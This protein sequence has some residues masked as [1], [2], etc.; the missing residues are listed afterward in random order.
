MP[1]HILIVNPD[2]ALAGSLREPLASGGFEVVVA[3]DFEEAASALKAQPFHAIVTAHHLGSHNGLHLVLRARLDRPT[4]V[5][6][7]TSAI[8]D[9]QLDLEAAAFGAV[10][11]VQPWLDAAPLLDV[12]RS[13]GAQPTV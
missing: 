1:P 12:L 7:I 3:S 6:V 8:S 11:L 9:P 4:L 5:A 13:A 2:R 10:C